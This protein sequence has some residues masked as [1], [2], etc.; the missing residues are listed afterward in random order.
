M[1]LVAVSELPIAACS[2]TRF[3]PGEMQSYVP[4]IP[5]FNYLLIELLVNY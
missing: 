5:N 4:D 3:C 1:R 2:V